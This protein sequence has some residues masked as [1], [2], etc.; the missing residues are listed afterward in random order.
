MKIKRTLY[1]TVAAV[2]ALLA[3]VSCS[4]EIYSGSVE[5]GRKVTLTLSYQGL[6]QKVMK[7]RATAEENQLNNLQVFVFDANE[8]NGKHRLVGWTYVGHDDLVQDGSKGGV[9][10]LTTTGSRIIY[11]VA[12]TEGGTYNIDDTSIPHNATDAAGWSETAI[13]SGA[14]EFTLEQFKEIMV[15]RTKTVINLTEANFF[16]SGMLNN[17]NAV[18]ILATGGGNATVQD[19]ANSS[20]NDFNLIKLHRVVAKIK[21][22]VTKSSSVQEFTPTGY[23]ICNVPLETPLITNAIKASTDADNFENIKR[24]L[25]DTDT[26]E[27]K[28]TDNDGKETTTEW[29]TFSFYLPGNRQNDNLTTEQKTA[30]EDAVK[31]AA[32]AGK[33]EQAWLVREADTG[34]G[35][36][37]KKFTN[38][39]EYATYLILRGNYVGSGSTKDIGNKMRGNAIYYIH[40]GEFNKTNGYTDFNVERNCLYTYRITVTG[41]ESIKVE[42]QKEDLAGGQPGA[43]EGYAFDFTSTGKFYTVDSHYEQVNMK[44]Y[45]AD[46]TSNN[47]WDGFYFKIDEPATQ[48]SPVYRIPLKSEKTS[49]ASTDNTGYIKVGDNVIYEY[50]DASGN[51][52]QVTDPARSDVQSTWKLVQIKQA[53]DLPI[54][55]V[56]GNVLSL[57]EEAKLESNNLGWTEFTKGHDVEYKEI[58]KKDANGNVIAGTKD[59][60]KRKLLYEVLREMAYNVLKMRQEGKL[61]GEKDSAGNVDY[62]KVTN[63]KDDFFDSF[64]EKDYNGAYRE[65]TCFIKENYYEQVSW[66]KFTDTDPRML[67]IAKNM[68]VGDDKRSIYADLFYGIEQYP[69][70]TTYDKTY[71]DK[72]KTDF[73]IGYGMETIRNDTRR[74]DQTLVPVK[75]STGV[76]YLST[77]LQNKY[78]GYGRL[79]QMIDL[80]FFAPTSDKDAEL[81]NFINGTTEIKWSSFNTDSWNDGTQKNFYWEQGAYACMSRNRDLNGDGIIQPR[82]V[83]WYCPDI[84]QLTGIWI[85]EE[86]IQNKKARL[87]TGSTAAIQEDVAD[88]DNGWTARTGG[89]HYYSNRSTDN[90]SQMRP[91]LWAEEGFAVNV[92]GT[93]A[94][95]SD[96]YVRCVRNLYPKD[97]EAWLDEGMNPPSASGSWRDPVLGF[98]LDT[99]YAYGF[100]TRFY[101]YDETTRTVELPYLDPEALRTTF[102]ERELIKHTERGATGY[103]N[104]PKD[105]FVIAKYN[106][107]GYEAGGTSAADDATLEAAGVTKQGDT[108][109][110][111]TQT[112]NETICKNYGEGGYKWRAPNERELAMMYHTGQ[113]AAESNFRETC[114]TSSTFPTIRQGWTNG[115]G[116]HTMQRPPEVDAWSNN[117]AIRC[118]RDAE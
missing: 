92:N 43:V 70:Y 109:I 37:A 77:N 69:I 56:D 24:N 89:E 78:P 54:T 98:N 28:T 90:T 118:V 61:D 30:I 46:F 44:F 33:S 102:S 38:A 20:D 2:F 91:V 8:E 71:A 112:D 48:N 117:A 17:G 35:E 93:F 52:V 99:M 9:T 22:M 74:F 11:G 31:K 25:A 15:N 68:D 40:L 85:G 107:S 60:D 10:V 84:E 19:P 80:M 105:K 79:N 7:T 45:K 66:S 106:T 101:N 12:N 49:S 58:F 18:D 113:Y 100:Y 34:T 116:Q 72:S 76:G 94:T 86:A 111:A 4:D 63:T 114:R 110:S 75:K 29:Q 50:T 53:S 1:A 27:E 55:D 41:L 81:T 108:T 14:S 64:D 36:G 6:D 82:E 65:Y 42:A 104:R 97:A 59:P 26:E 13:Q 62:S 95:N 39:P 5:T 115:G 96:F 51:T 103:V 16:M 21:V 83:R 67:L 57:S 32:A 73:I 3:I 47:T 88:T 23:T 87:F